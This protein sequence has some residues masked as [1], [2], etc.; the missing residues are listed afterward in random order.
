MNNYRPRPSIFARLSQW[1]NRFRP[2]VYPKTYTVEVY[3]NHPRVVNRITTV[4]VNIDAH[5]KD[6]ARLQVQRELSISVGKAVLTSK[7]K[8]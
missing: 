1:M 2:K 5:S 8:A 6:H 7:L 3:L 4:L